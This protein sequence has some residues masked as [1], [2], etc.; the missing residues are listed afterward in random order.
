[1]AAL[2]EVIEEISR[3]QTFVGSTPINLEGDALGPALSLALGIARLGKKAIVVNRDPVPRSLDFLRYHEI[4]RKGT[5]SQNPVM[6]SRFWIGG[7][8][9]NGPV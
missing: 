2:N 8:G 7:Y 4:F 3:N 1:M 5:G 9:Q 6:S